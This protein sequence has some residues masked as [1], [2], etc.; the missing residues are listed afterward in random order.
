MT[1][2]CA[3][4]QYYALFG[5]TYHHKSCTHT[6]EILSIINHVSTSINLTAKSL[7]LAY[8]L[9]H[10]PSL[11]RPGPNYSHKNAN[12]Q[13]VGL[14][15][16]PCFFLFFVL[17]MFC[18]IRTRLKELTNEFLD[19]LNHGDTPCMKHLAGYIVLLA[20]EVVLVDVSGYFLKRA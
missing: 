18:S 7:G 15:D 10:A 20:G 2:L 6:S 17:L 8:M 1:E 5:T 12:L 16:M 3:A 14:L 19:A 4:A 11:L 9:G 13:L